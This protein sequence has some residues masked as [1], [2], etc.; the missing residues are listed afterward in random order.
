MKAAKSPISKRLQSD[1]Q[2]CAQEG[3]EYL[4]SVRDCKALVAALRI[5]SPKQ[6]GDR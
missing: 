6:V 4:L 2:W 3:S 1:L 5:V